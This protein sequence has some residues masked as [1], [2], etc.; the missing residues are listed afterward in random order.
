MMPYDEI[1][2][3]HLT[4]NNTTVSPA[5]S[6]S[7][8]LSVTH[9]NPSLYTVEVGNVNANTTLILSQAYDTGWKAYQIQNSKFKIQN[10]LNLALPF[11]FGTE[12]KDHVKVNNWENGWVLPN[13]TLNADNYTLDAKRYTLVLVFLPQYLQYLGFMLLLFPIFWCFRAKNLTK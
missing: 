3:V 11:L 8:T 2:N 10:Y 7:V 6:S 1:K 13:S 12:I 5:Q 4:K 9:P